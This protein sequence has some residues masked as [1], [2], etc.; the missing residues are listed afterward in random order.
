M[1]LL[2]LWDSQQNILYRLTTAMKAVI[3]ALLA[4]ATVSYTPELSE[5]GEL[6]NKTNVWRIKNTFSFFNTFETTFLFSNSITYF[7]IRM[8]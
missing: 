4:C 1:F 8:L 3:I 7:R 2:R 6:F 5:E